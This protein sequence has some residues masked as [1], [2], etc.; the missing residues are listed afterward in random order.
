MSKARQQRIVAGALIMMVWGTVL[1]A[2][3]AF[4]FLLNH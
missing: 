4:T 1:F 2:A 3:L